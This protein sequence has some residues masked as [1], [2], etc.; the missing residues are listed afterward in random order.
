MKTANRLLSFLS[1]INTLLSLKT[2]VSIR[3]INKLSYCFYHWQNHY[4]LINHKQ[5]FFDRKY[6]TAH[7]WNVNA[8]EL[9]PDFIITHYSKPYIHMQCSDSA[10][11]IHFTTGKSPAF[12]KTFVLLCVRLVWTICC[13][14]EFARERKFLQTLAITHCLVCFFPAVKALLQVITSA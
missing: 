9:Y 4:R 8:N 6:K 13:Y 12:M 2:F 11:S 10:H 5:A 14:Y 7:L 1:E 3:V